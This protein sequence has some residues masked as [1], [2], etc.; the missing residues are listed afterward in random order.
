[1][2]SFKLFTLLSIFCTSSAWAV[3]SV[4]VLSGIS[5][6]VFLNGRE[7]RESSPVNLGATLETRRGQATLLL[8]K[9]T[10]VHL[11]AQTLIE[12]NQSFLDSQS[13]TENTALTLKYGATRALV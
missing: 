3:T 6:Q 2:T 13:K 10:V 9:E 4:G 8:G 12:I 11:G 5:G 7:V 1:M